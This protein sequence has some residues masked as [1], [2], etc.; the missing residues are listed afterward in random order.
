MTQHRRRDSANN[1]Q[2]IT[3]SKS[4]TQSTTGQIAGNQYSLVAFIQQLTQINQIK[5]LK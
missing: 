1:H 5:I 4:L 3:D 2:H